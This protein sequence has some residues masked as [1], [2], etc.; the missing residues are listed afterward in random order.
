MLWYHL[1]SLAVLAAPVDGVAVRDIQAMVSPAERDLLQHR[2][3]R[4]EI[5]DIPGAGRYI[6]EEKPQVV[7]DAVAR[8]SQMAG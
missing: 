8:L 1:I 3:R 5:Q 6:H 7:L 2:E 4:V